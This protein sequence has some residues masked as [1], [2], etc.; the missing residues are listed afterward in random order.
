[1]SKNSILILITFEYD[2][3]YHIQLNLKKF[4]YDVDNKYQYKDF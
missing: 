4:R 2:D 1:M 3:N